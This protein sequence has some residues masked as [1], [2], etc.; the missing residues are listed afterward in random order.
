M[1]EMDIV[2]IAI[3]AW[4]HRTEMG[5]SKKF[6]GC[7]FVLSLTVVVIQVAILVGMHLEISDRMFCGDI[8]RHIETQ[9][10]KPTNF[11]ANDG[12][13]THAYFKNLWTD[14]YLKQAL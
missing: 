11:F 4:T 10:G 12:N 9:A 5:F 8:V 6:I 7:S 3:V 2:K 1:S 14:T 13:D